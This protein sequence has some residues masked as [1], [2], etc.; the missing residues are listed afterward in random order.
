MIR[1]TLAQTQAAT[2]CIEV[3]NAAKHGMP[4]PHGTGFFVTPDGWFVTA[5]HVVTENGQPNGPVRSD[6]A[7]I[8]L[9]KE[10]RVD[11]PTPPIQCWGGVSLH[12][13]LPQYDF[14]LLRVDFATNSKAAW[15]QGKT[16][17]PFISVSQRQLAEGEPV[18]AFGYPL[19]S[20]E[21]NTSGPVMIGSTT[22]SPRVT[23]AIVASTM[24][25]T[26]MIMSNTDPRVYVLDKALNYGNSGGPIVA[27]ETGRVHAICSRFQPVYVPQPHLKDQAGKPLAVWVPSLYGVV[28]SLGNAE[29][30][31][32][33]ETV[34]VGLCDD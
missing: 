9:S 7:Q 24:Y 33:L 1:K 34:S 8:R 4:T 31:K 2:F 20:A 18:Y 21:L 30:L 19:S 32:L 16:G 11:K 27:S 13:L 26:G 12:T 23:S 3:P 22:L 5:A 28:S 6:L 10:L 14:A 17:F 25:T 15:L 29:L